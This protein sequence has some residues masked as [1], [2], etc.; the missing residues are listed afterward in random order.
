MEQRRGR[1][2]GRT[3]HAAGR[4]EEELVA[5]RVQL[6]EELAHARVDVRLVEHVAHV[7][8]GVVERDES[9]KLTAITTAAC[10]PPAEPSG[11]PHPAPRRRPA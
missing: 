10:G 3:D 4:E 9:L 11:A 8:H 1:V 2:D 6:A 7:P 5:A